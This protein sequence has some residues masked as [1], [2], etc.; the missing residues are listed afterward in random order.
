MMY[1]FP[2]Q[3]GRRVKLCLSITLNKLSYV[4]NYSSMQVANKAVSLHL[5]NQMTNVNIQAGGGWKLCGVIPVDIW[6]FPQPL[7]IVHL[8]QPLLQATS[9]NNTMGCRQILTA[10][11]PL[12]YSIEQHQKTDTEHTTSLPVGMLRAIMSASLML[13]KYLTRARILL[14]WAAINTFW[15]F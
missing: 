12:P 14:P 4:C 9:A 2:F 8:P 7:L 3:H 10:Q 11:V 1:R 15:P 13:S 5:T 6:L